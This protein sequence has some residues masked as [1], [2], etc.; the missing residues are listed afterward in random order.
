MKQPR[1]CS[2][3]LGRYGNQKSG[4]FQEFVVGLGDC[5]IINQV[6]TRRGRER[7]GPGR[8]DRSL[9]NQRTR[10]GRGRGKTFGS[11]GA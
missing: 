3:F 1:L 6:E 8:M 2:L 10:A 5:I 4:H 7:L 11:D 9:S